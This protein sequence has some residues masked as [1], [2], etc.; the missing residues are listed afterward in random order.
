MS[1]TLCLYGY[2]KDIDRLYRNLGWL[3]KSHDHIFDEILIIHQDCEASNV[4]VEISGDAYRRVRLLFTKD[5]P[6]IWK[7]FN[8]DLD[9]PK[10]LNCYP[11][12]DSP[13]WYPKHLVNQLVGIHC[14][15]S[16]YIVFNDG[17]CVMV[18]NDEPGWI[19]KGIALLESDRTCLIVSPSDG[20]PGRTWIMSQQFWLADKE[21]VAAIDWNCWDGNYIDGG[22]FREWY[23]M[24]EGRIGTYMYSNKLSRMVLTDEWRYYHDPWHHKVPEDLWKIAN[25]RLKP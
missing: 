14:A 24:A 13:H 5:F 3:I 23:G 4:E 20:A 16:D 22:P 11:G 19:N 10:Y 1:V 21:R 12:K 9:D 18:R 2:E 15:T 17:D 8:I 6:L 25:E 7:K